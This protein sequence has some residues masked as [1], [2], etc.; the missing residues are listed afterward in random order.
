TL[1]R[2]LDEVDDNREELMLIDRDDGYGD[3]GLLAGVLA[4]GERG[5]ERRG[6]AGRQADDGLVDAGQQVA[7]ADLVGDAARGVD[8]L[9]ADRGAQVGAEEV[10]VGDR[11]GDADEAGGALAQR[12]GALPD[13][14]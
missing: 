14:L 6:L 10:A 2:H 7:G 9:V 3:L 11:A 1:E 13:V 4:T 8:L 12:P 5:G